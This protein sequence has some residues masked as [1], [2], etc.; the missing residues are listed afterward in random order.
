[1]GALVL[2]GLRAADVTQRLEAE[3]RSPLPV[4]ATPRYRPNLANLEAARLGQ[5]GRF[6]IPVALEVRRGQTLSEVFGDLGLA[7]SDATAAVA[8]VT[9]HL[10]PRKLQAGNRYLAFLSPESTIE[11]MVF[12]LEARGRVWV[13]RV[14]DRWQ[15]RFDPYR[16]ESRELRVTGTLDG[17][18]EAALRRA[19]APA[20][21]AYQLADVF[22]WDLDFNRD[23]RTGDRFQVLFSSEWVEGELHRVGPIRAALYE[24]R[25]QR[26]EAFQHGEEGGYYDAEGRPLRKQFL[27]SPLPFS[28]VTS[29]FTNRRFHP[30]LKVYRAHHGVDFGAPAGT[31]V[32]VTS[33]GVVTLATWTSGG[34][35][36]TVKVR[37]P[38]EYETAYLHLSRYA[39]GIAPGRRVRQG[40][41]IGYVGASG[42]ATAPHLDYR[43]KHRGRYLDPLRLGAVPAPPLSPEEL[44]RFVRVRDQLRAM[45][46]HGVAPQQLA[47]RG[48]LVAGPHAGP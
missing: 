13:E 23:L 21:L 18:L 12:P 9:A 26:F 17:S 27:R 44:S 3:A 25:G 29:R 47:G 16:I 19:G 28:R 37:H 32:R 39:D 6:E 14:G 33:S 40:D 20:T 35:G 4:E 34:G 38:G 48:S 2:G 11:R 24:N 45:L 31:P 41:I 22:Q 1:M 8:A 5:L 30:V 7:G 46:D 43:V 15:G 42:L 10:D 36:R